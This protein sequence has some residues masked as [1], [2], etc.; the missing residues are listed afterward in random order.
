[1][2]LQ[3]TFVDNTMKMCNKCKE[4][5]LLD[6]FSRDKYKKDGYQNQCKACIK[7]YREANKEKIL[8]SVKAYREAN[9][10]KIAK[11][12][13]AYNEANKD[14]I[15]AYY[16]ANK[17]KIAER[18]KAYY[19]ANK[20]KILER[21]KAYR[22]AN[23]DK[24]KAYKEANR[25]RYNEIYSR[26]RAR[27]RKAIPKFLRNCEVER[28]RIRDIF[29]LRQVISEA[30]GI[31]HHVDH[32]W[33]LSKGGPHWSGNLQILTAT[34]NMNKNASVCKLTKKN[35]KASLKIAR[36]EYLNEDNSNGHRD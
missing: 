8:E 23:K 2:Q 20:E 4:T 11:R 33:P 18:R 17:E 6:M 9:K 12:K 36:K 14:K 35:I 5:K 19:E 13:K 28:K 15:K 32:M 24:I 30:T 27:K 16:E 1:M 21:E 34:E 10:D 7:A 25:G 3:F 31:E 29:K 22:E 26:R